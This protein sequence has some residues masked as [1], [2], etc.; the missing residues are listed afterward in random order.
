MYMHGGGSNPSANVVTRGGRGGGNPSRGRGGSGHGGGGRAGFG[1][2]SGGC[3]GGSGRGSN[4]QA[5]VFY[6]LY[7]KEGH[8]VVRCFKRFDAS[9][10]LK[11]VQHW[12]PLRMA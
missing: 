6:Q 2:G 5:G 11:K 10:S 1:R 9:F 8:A 7:G 12:Q 4:F 3:G